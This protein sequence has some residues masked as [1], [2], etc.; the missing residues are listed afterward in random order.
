MKGEVPKVKA[1]RRARPSQKGLGKFASS[2]EGRAHVPAFLVPPHPVAV[3]PDNARLVERLRNSLLA[4]TP[5]ERHRYDSPPSSAASS[6]GPEAL[7]VDDDDMF[8][9]MP[10]FVVPALSGPAS[11]EWEGW[12]D[13][14]RAV[15][16]LRVAD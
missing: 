5:V 15:T 10:D 16:N 4:S 3:P 11:L 9:M 12:I 1:P 8:G 14:D 2:D 7:D 13:W 6:C